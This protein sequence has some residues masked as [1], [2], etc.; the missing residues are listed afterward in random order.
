[1]TSAPELGDDSHPSIAALPRWLRL[2]PAAIVLWM[3]TSWPIGL[4]LD[5]ARRL[6]LRT[7]TP[8]ATH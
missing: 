6:A 1:M 3:A 5:P 2:L 8:P 7:S 4:A